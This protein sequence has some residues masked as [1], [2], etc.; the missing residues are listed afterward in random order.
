[1]ETQIPTIRVSEVAARAEGYAKSLASNLEGLNVQFSHPVLDTHGQEIFQK[2]SGNMD[3]EP[4][5]AQFIPVF[6]RLFFT[7]MA[8]RYIIIPD[9]D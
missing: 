9:H 3:L 2:I 5:P 8:S 4:M 6:E 1:M 7:Y